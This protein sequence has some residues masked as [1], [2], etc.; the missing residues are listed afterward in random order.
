MYMV[1]ENA[2]LRHFGKPMHEAKDLDAR[3]WDLCWLCRKPK[4][5]TLLKQKSP[6]A[7][8]KQL[9]Q[10]DFGL[11]GSLLLLSHKFLKQQESH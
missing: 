1:L 6:I 5:E 10:Q 8:L 3:P 7:I 9:F 11:K 4:E 2:V